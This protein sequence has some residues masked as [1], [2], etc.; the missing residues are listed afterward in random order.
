[1]SDLLLFA[2]MAAA[3]GAKELSEFGKRFHLACEQ[4]GRS[5]TSAE[6]DAGLNRGYLTPIIYGERGQSAINPA[7]MTALARLLHVNFE[8]LVTGNGPMR[9]EGRETTPAEQAITFARSVGVREDAISIAWERNKDR[10]SD[11]DAWAWARLIDDEAR[12]LDSAGLPRPEAVH[13]KHKQTQ[14]LMKKRGK[15]NAEPAETKREDVD[16]ERSRELRRAG[17]M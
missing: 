17:R 15:L 8:W 12:R 14:R 3:K 1:M 10:E 11:L 4:E 7:Y 13:E 9:R 2:S 5:P 6:R 16:S